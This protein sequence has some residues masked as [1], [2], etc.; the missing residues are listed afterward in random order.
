MG[1]RPAQ[2]GAAE[3][4]AIP[5]RPAAPAGITAAAVY[6][7]VQWCTAIRGLPHRIPMSNLFHA[8]Q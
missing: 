2:Y 1:P 5:R 8:A 7:A 4:S 3:V 6:Y